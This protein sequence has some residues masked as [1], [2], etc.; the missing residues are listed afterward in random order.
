[1]T[2]TMTTTLPLTA[3]LLLLADDGSASSLQL[4]ERGRATASPVPT[5]GSPWPPALPGERRL[6]V[7]PGQRVRAQWLAIAAHSE[8]QARAVAI[9]ALSADLAAAPG[10]THVAL[11][12]P[13]TGGTP[14]LVLATS[15]QDMR[16]WLQQASVLGVRPDRVLPDYLLLP[17]SVPCTVASHRGTWLVHGGDIAFA[18]EPAIAAQVL[19][20]VTDAPLPDAPPLESILLAGALDANGP[21]LRQGEFLPAGATRRVQGSRRRIALWTA[22]L[23]ASPLLATLAEGLVH[24]ART[25]ANDAIAT[26]I[27]TRLG[28]TP[29]ATGAA[30]AVAGERAL[31]ESGERF[32]ADAGAVFAAIQAQPGAMLERFDYGTDVLEAVVR[33]PDAASA[34]AIAASLQ[35]TGFQ[36]QAAAGAR[37]GGQQFTTLRITRTP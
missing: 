34:D 25:R 26:T 37:S 5:P 9:E 8:A 17:P 36:V 31:L 24:H 13:S 19:G 2:M 28:V 29:G 32:A 1:M 27:A 7:V 11:G 16:Q 14:R 3:R 22:L 33:H 21:D 15:R 6:L 4:D 12:P 30:A 10:D 18:A 23:L 20:A 35:Q